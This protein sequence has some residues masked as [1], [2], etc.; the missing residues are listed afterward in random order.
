MEVP[1]LTRLQ[2]RGCL[3]FWET[4]YGGEKGKCSL[5]WNC[6]AFHTSSETQ[7]NKPRKQPWPLSVYKSA[8]TEWA[9]HNEWIERDPARKTS[10]YHDVITFWCSYWQC[11]GGSV[12]IHSCIQNLLVKVL[13]EFLPGEALQLPWQGGEHSMWWKVWLIKRQT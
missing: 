1:N 4:G 9:V 2:S 11:C 10:L 6:V 8:F 12:T 3:L 13:L 5:L 7:H